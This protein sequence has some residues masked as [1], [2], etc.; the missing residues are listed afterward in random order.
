MAL[1]PNSEGFRTLLKKK[2]FLRLWLAQ[3]ISMTI[4]N[5]SNY[6]LIILIQE[7]THSTTLIGL[8][9]ISFS[10]PAV[11]F[12][13]PAGVFVD[14]LQKRRV[15]WIS[16]CLRSIA[17][18]FFV[19]SLLLDRGALL[20]IYLL[21]FIISA[22]GQFFT[23]AEGASIPMLVTEDELTPALS[24]FNITFMLS[25]ALGFVLF[26]P[27][28]LSVLPTFSIFHITIDAI[29]QLYTLVALLYL[30]CASLILFIPKQSFKVAVHEERNVTPIASQTI[31]VLNNVWH[32]MLQGWQFIRIDKQ[33]FQAVIQL[34]FAGV[35]LLVIG[36][37][38]T[39]IVTL[40]LDLP[41]TAMAFVFAPAGIGLVIGSVL[42]PRIMQALGRSR[43]IFVG[44]V[45]LTVAT[46]LV[47][48]L[49][50]L[51]KF[52]E[53]TT[54]KSN[55]LLTIAIA[56]LMFIAGISLDF[57]NIP[58][59]TTMQ[60]LSPDWI[61]GRVLSLQ[62]VLYNACSIPIILFV[63]GLSDLYGI[64]AVLYLLAAGEIGFGLL[65]IYYAHRHP[66]RPLVEEEAEI[67]PLTKKD[68]TENATSLTEEVN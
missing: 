30:V 46:L 26:A 10:L 14:H 35:L 15:L 59:Q 3:L 41:P 65:G 18:L 22:I 25:Q 31:G 42:M 11:L 9:I 52:L 62:L 6:A 57:I 24:L 19:V 45:T 34:S 56:A 43:T 28:A 20:P 13:A 1:A 63:G 60:E 55:P 68:E 23:P 38:A 7:L 48:S 39:P 29:I 32:E 33:L 64:S 50:I 37:L 40:L 4:L 8:A 66:P 54:W 61:K 2:N 5:A 16:N 67:V 53:P 44:I 17:T 12:G 51:A 21:T 27:I 36:Q 58:A 49:T 47:P